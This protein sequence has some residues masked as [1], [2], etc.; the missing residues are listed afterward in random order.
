LSF[1]ALDLWETSKQSSL[2]QSNCLQS[3]TWKC[4]W[5]MMHYCAASC[6]GHH[7][8][9]LFAMNPHS[10]W[11]NLFASFVASP[12]ASSSSWKEA[13]LLGMHLRCFRTGAQRQDLHQGNLSQ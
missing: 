8:R 1:Y 7:R 12:V 6:S 4:S 9:R 11:Q 3:E 2:P 10:A 5:I 13:A